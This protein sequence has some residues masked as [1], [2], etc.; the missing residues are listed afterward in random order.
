ML[1]REQDPIGIKEGGG[2]GGGA[3]SLNWEA[4]EEGQSNS[5]ENSGE[6]YISDYSERNGRKAKGIFKGGEGDFLATRR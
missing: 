1:C 5:Y 2:G 6:G 3:I 4:E